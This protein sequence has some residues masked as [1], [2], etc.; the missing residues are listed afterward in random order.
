M[1]AIFC[2]VFF[3]DTK[4][5]IYLKEWALVY[6]PKNGVFEKLLGNVASDLKIALIHGVDSPEQVEDV[7]KRREFLAGVVFDHPSVNIFSSFLLIM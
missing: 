3:S 6:S 7:I 4:N 2:I 1:F 5:D